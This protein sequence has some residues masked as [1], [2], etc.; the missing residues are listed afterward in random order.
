MLTHTIGTIAS[1]FF[2]DVEAQHRDCNIFGNV[3]VVR[4]GVKLLGTNFAL[5]HTLVLAYV[6]ILS[7]LE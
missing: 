5:I 4:C 7:F 6:I 2:L 3:N 1:Y